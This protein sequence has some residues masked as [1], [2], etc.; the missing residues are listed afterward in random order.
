LQKHEAFFL[1]LPI[2]RL[3]L[4]ALMLVSS[5]RRSAMA[6]TAPERANFYTRLNTFGVF[7]AY[8]GNSSHMI[9]G[10]AQ[11]RRLLGFGVEYRR[12]LILGRIA[13]WQ[14]SLEL[15][16]VALESDPIVHSVLNQQTPTVATYVSN[17]RMTNA[18]I[19]SSYSFSNT[20]PSGVVYSGSMTTTC[21]RTWTMG[22]AF[23][24]VG[25]QWN[26]RPRQRLQ[27]VVIVH[28]GYMYSTQAIPIDFA[29][30]FNFTF[31]VG[32]G[33]EFYRSQNTSFRVDYRYHHTSNHDTAD[34]NPGI[35]NGIFQIT[36]AFGR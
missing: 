28:G 22:E 36:Y 12:R 2:C 32:A 33:L 10:Y 9:L 15:L 30:S 35:D 24:P 5:F 23:S 27:P 8:S 25:S 17:Y 20:D 11:N 16:P 14:Y 26:F 1:L 19:P 18:C 21:N 13:S 6:Q 3:C 7:G 31:D 34:A 29:G 4:V